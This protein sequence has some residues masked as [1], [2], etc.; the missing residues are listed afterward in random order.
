[1]S[2]IIIY[3][4][5]HMLPMKKLWRYEYKSYYSILKFGLSDGNALFLESLLRYE[6]ELC[7][8]D[9]DVHSS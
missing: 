6:L 8:L 5:W 3:F 2:I 9:I 4:P 1:V 7:I